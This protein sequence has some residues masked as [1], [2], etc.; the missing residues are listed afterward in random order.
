M[1][2]GVFITA[3]S[4]VVIAQGVVGLGKVCVQT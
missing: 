3:Y 2:Q 1:L 4:D